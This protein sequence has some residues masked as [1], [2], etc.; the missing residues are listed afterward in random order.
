MNRIERLLSS[1][2]GAVLARPWFDR[3]ALEFL[4]RWFFPLSRLWAAAGSAGGSPEKFFAEVPMVADARQASRVR[5]ALARFEA[6]RQAAAAAESRWEDAFFGPTRVAEHELE[7]IEQDRL[8]ARVRLNQARARFLFLRRHPDVRPV[9]WEVPTPVEIAALYA[10]LLKD[11][12]G[13][14]QVPDPVPPVSQSHALPAGGGRDYWLRFRSPSQRMDDLVYARVHEPPAAKDPPTLIFLHGIGVE[15]DHW[16]GMIDEVRELVRRGVRVVRLE[17]PWHGRR[18]PAGRYGGEQFVATMPLGTLQFFGA[19]VR[20]AAILIDWCRRHTRGPVA[21]GGSSLG[22]H[23]ARVTAAWASTWPA[24]LRPDALLLISPC[25]SLEDAAIDGAF[26]EVWGVAQATQLKGWGP[27]IRGRWLALIDPRH[28]P[29]VPADRIVTVLG[30]RDRVTPY[31]SGREVIARLGIPRRNVF[32]LD[33]GH[34]SLPLA[35]VRNHAPLN[36]LWE[37]LEFMG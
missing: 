31:P 29:A 8:R 22:A 21:V 26:S 11:P 24:S 28:P 32:V 13:P 6:L 14:F 20:E 18:T 3:A 5:P 27:E 33:H 17:A 37:I 25:G 7:R 9:R 2:L 34:F 1:P 4:R 19:M 15:F 16:H 23:V 10:R 36:R 12:A 30:R 35:L